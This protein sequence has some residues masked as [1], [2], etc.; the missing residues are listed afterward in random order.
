MTG[1]KLI[2]EINLR[3]ML[4]ESRMMSNRQEQT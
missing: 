1:A 2:V 3:K 4:S